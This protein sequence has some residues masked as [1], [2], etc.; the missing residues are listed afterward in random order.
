MHLSWVDWTTPI[1][2]V[3][4]SMKDCWTTCKMQ[5]LDLSD[6]NTRKYD[7]ITPILPRSALASNLSKNRLQTS[8][9]GLQM[10]AW[11][12]SIL[13]CRELHT[14]AV[15]HLWSAASVIGWQIGAA[16]FRNTNCDIWP[17]GFR[18]GRPGGLEFSALCS[19]RT[20][21]SF[22]CFRRGLKTFL[23]R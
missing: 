23:I 3:M 1:P 19:K 15:C 11:F 22:N 13:P 20:T 4:V 8:D 17:T 6:T 2:C 21:L 12:V 7:Y 18:G 5:L 9:H 16:C 14:T 10:S